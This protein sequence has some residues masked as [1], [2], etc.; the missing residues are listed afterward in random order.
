MS[1]KCAWIIN[2]G[3]DDTPAQVAAAQLSTYGLPAE[4]QKWPKGEDNAWMNSAQE[5][6]QR[7]ASVVILVGP[8]SELDPATRAELALFRL[9]LHTHRGAPVNAVSLLAGAPDSASTSNGHTGILDDWLVPADA[10]WPAKAVARAHAPV[11]PSWPVRLGMHAHERLGAWLE[12]HPLPGQASSG[13]C[14]GVAGEGAAID[15]H[16]VGPMGTLPERSVNEYELQGL[17]FDIGALAFE[18]W[19]LQNTIAPDQSYYVRI[20]GRPSHL[21]ISSLPEGELGDVHIVS[22]ES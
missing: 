13:V 14:V 1:Q 4:G 3:A 7:N 16:A 21:A 11:A 15:F 12:V 9:A 20:A 5:A 2:F 10:R 22:V 6:A 8:A 18:A 17:K 19:A